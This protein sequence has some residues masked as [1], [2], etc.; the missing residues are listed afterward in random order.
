MR[1]LELSMKRA[2]IEIIKDR[3]IHDFGQNIRLNITHQA[4]AIFGAQKF[5]KTA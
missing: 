2:T 3:I 4:G 5:I 1:T